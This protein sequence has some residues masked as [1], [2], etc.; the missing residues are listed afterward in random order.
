MAHNYVSCSQLVTVRHLPC[1]YVA[2]LFLTDRVTAEQPVKKS[3]RFYGDS[4][5]YKIQPHSHLWADCLDNV[6]SLTSHNHGLSRGELDKV[7]ERAQRP[8]NPLHSSHNI[9]FRV[10]FYFQILYQ[11]SVHVLTAMHATCT[12][13]LITLIISSSF[14]LSP[15]PSSTSTLRSSDGSVIRNLIQICLTFTG[16]CYIDRRATSA[17]VNILEQNIVFHSQLTN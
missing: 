5:I 11:I 16:K 3:P 13:H 14:L 9:I 12:I 10:V 7:Y 6:G 1:C 4:K 2:E 15:A 17:M 8:V